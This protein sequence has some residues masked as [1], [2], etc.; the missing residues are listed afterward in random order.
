MHP[1]EQSASGCDH[2]LQEAKLRLNPGRLAPCPFNDLPFRP[3]S[4]SLRS[5][6]LAR[7]AYRF[8]SGDVDLAHFN[9]GGEEARAADPLGFR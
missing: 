6:G 3:L 1:I 7:V 8:D 2:V 4:P 5:L 9:L